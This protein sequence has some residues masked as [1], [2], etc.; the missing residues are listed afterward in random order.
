MGLEGS[1]NKLSVGIVTRSG[2]ILANLRDTYNAPTGQGFLPQEVAKHHRSK[3][4][5]L[6]KQALAIAERKIEDI[7][8][9]AYT[10]G[11]GMGGPLASV[12]LVAKTLALVLNVPLIPV[13]HCVAHIEMGRLVTGIDNPIVLYAS[14]GNT[15]IIA[16]SKGRYRI[17]GEALD[18]AVGN[19]LDRFA[20]E[21]GIPNDPAP[22]LN[23][24]LAARRHRKRSQDAIEPY[25]SL[26]E[27]IPI[28][29]KGMDI[30]CS[31]L[32]SW[33]KS[34]YEKNI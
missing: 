11:P 30:S 25:P 13:N 18:I 6:I 14:G 1:A 29:V 31:G 10:R 15:Q 17:F 19:C 22:G 26:V 27:G 20:R 12:A 24:E 34:Y 33:L 32:N 7:S 23:I 3:I 16:F 4:V 21:C 8:M 28:S 2:K 9:I 5:G